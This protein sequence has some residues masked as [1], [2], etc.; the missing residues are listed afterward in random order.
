MKHT[1]VIA[2]IR[3]ICC[4]G[5]GGGAIMPTLLKTLHDLVP[6]DSN[7]FF[8]VDENDDISDICAEKLLPPEVMSLYF[9]EFYDYQVGGFRNVIARTAKRKLGIDR[10]NREPGFYTSDYYNLVW[11]EHLNAHHVMY[12]VIQEQGKRLG[13]LSL[14]RASKDEPFSRAEEAQLAQVTHYIAHGL[15][16]APLCNHGAERFRDTDGSGLITINALGEIQHVSKEGKRLLFLASYATISR[17]SLLTFDGDSMPPALQQIG[18]NLQ[19][20]FCGLEVPPPVW[21]VVNSRG[22]FVFRAFWLDAEQQAGQGL[23]GVTIQH[24]E[25]LPLRLLS[26]LNSW[27][28]T[29]QQKRVILLL[30]DSASYGHIAST[31]NVSANT[32]NYHVKQI[33]D[34][35]SVHNRDAMLDKLLTQ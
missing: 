9:R 8:W 23:I 32:V 20:I 22:R 7:A 25:P 4:L 16:A 5:L 13:Q 6:S 17:Q 33:Y 18:Q 34:R 35:L 15:N 31:L 26:Q 30:S 21:N 11:R 12:A 1:S 27:P 2:H 10:A 29:D 24:Q 19:S 3:Q 28:F 14:Y